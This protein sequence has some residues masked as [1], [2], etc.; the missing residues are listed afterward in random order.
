MINASRKIIGSVTSGGYRYSRSREGGIGF[1]NESEMSEGYFNKFN[2]YV[3]L[4][5]VSS[6]HYMLASATIKR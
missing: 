3:L 4:R 2:N 6:P 5:K 1:V